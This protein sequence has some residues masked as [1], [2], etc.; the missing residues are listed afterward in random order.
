MTAADEERRRFAAE[1]RAKGRMPNPSRR[2]PSTPELEH[3]ELLRHATALRDIAN[4]L[5]DI[6]TRGIGARYEEEYDDG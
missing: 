5:S 3:D 4:R 2:P 6:V 1:M